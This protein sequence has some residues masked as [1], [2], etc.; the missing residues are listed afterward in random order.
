AFTVEPGA[1]SALVGDDELTGG[2]VA[3][4]AQMFAGDFVGGV[5]REVDPEVVSTATDR[6]LVLCNEVRLRPAVIA[7]A[8]LGEDARRLPAGVLAITSNARARDG[9]LAGDQSSLGAAVAG[10]GDLGEL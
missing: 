4:K 7:V 3:A 10:L 9:G 5:E 6:N 8:N 2:R 1:V